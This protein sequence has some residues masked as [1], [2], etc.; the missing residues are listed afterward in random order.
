M[1]WFCR[2]LIFQNQSAASCGAKIHLIP[3]GMGFAISYSGIR[4]NKR[5]AI[6]AY[7]GPAGP[8]AKYPRATAVSIKP[9]A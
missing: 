7:T 3:E 1:S 8:A 6:R 5:N 4:R 2:Q 9:R